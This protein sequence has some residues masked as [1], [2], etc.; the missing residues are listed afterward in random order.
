[1]QMKTHE[2]LQLLNCGL[3]KTNVFQNRTTP[4]FCVRLSGPLRPPRGW[5][6]GR[7]NPAPSHSSRMSRSS[8]AL[9]CRCSFAAAFWPTTS[10][11]SSVRDSLWSSSSASA[12]RSST[13]AIC[14]RSLR[15]S[16]WSS[17]GMSESADEPRPAMAGIERLRPN[18][19]T[20]R[21][22]KGFPR[23][24][25]MGF[26]SSKRSLGDSSSLCFVRTDPL[27]SLR[28]KDLFKEQQK[29]RPG[30]PHSSRPSY[31]PSPIPGTR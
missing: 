30:G 5:R 15:T 17:E 7:P 23:R 21:K 2:K 25:N 4:I 9:L 8:D 12:L 28:V 10:A 20:K 13:A 31:D 18:R 6:G 26:S 16:S 22:K 29:F 11:T 14:W 27:N 24:R 1:M 19:A 3:F